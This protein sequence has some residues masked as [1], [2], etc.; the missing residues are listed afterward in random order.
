MEFI[1]TLRMRHQVRQLRE[2]KRADN[3]LSPDDLSPLERGHLKDAFS[4]INTM[5][6]SLG[7]RMIGLGRDHRLTLVDSL[8]GGLRFKLELGP[9]L[10]LH[11]VLNLFC[12]DSIPG[13]DLIQDQVDTVQRKLQCFGDLEELLGAFDA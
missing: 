2:G 11:A 6:E 13:V 7:Q 3:F 10:V 9:D 4:L 1:G 12:P 8:P 5:Q